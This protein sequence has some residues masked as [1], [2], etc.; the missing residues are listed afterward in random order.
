MLSEEEYQLLKT[1]GIIARK[2]REIIPSIVREG[3]DALTIAQT[4][5]NKIIEYG[6]RPAFP[7]NICVD[8]VAAHF[9]PTPHENIIIPK[10]S[11]VKVDL[12]VECGGYI[13]DTA[14]TIGL[15]NSQA[16]L[17]EAA[18]NALKRVIKLIRAGI[19]VSEVGYV[20]NEVVS[21]YG[22][23][24]IK[25]LSGHEIGRYVLHTGT[26]IPNIKTKETT[27]LEN[28]KTYAIEPFVTLGASSGLVINSGSV[29]IFS[30]PA[31]SNINSRLSLEE[32]DFLKKL[33]E[34]TKGLP[35]TL[36]WIEK[37]HW[38]IHEKLLRRGIIRSYPVL[39]EK[40]G[41]PVAQ[42]EHT[43]LVHEDGCEVIT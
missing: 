22:F 14:I 18:E 41:L 6:G 39:V 33:R 32:L 25:N 10:A 7:C 13:A 19:K 28:G 2:V 11:L 34:K 37:E 21:R 29:N 17:I 42:A 16:E 1:A 4:V 5:E 35:Y 3:V 27:K 20:I 36:R 12:G 43:V 23:K 31:E 40:S 9:T 8:S 24:P 15:P 30:I 38:Q 26:S